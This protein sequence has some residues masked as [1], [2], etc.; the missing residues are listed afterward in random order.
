MKARSAIEHSFKT[1]DGEEIFYRTWPSLSDRQ[2]G[3]LVLLHRGHEHSG[4]V[5]HLVHELNLSDFACFAWDARGHGRSSG[6]RGFSPDVATSIRDVK[7]FTDHITDEYGIPQEKI[8]LIGQ[9]VGAILAAGWVH[10]YAPR[11]AGMV[12]AAPAFEIKLYAPS[13]RPFLRAVKALRGDFSVNSY[14]RPQF[15]THDKER[16]ASYREDPLISRPI[17]ANLLLDL[18]DHSKKLVED[19]EALVLLAPEVL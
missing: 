1:H 9:S 16:I 17:S 11:I 12:L 7:T 6:A 18:H 19:A 15:L 10:D 13:A 14:I 8:V 3:A 4:R 5:S 2:K